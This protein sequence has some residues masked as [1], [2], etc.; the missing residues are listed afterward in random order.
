M[1]KQ[2]DV[3]LQGQGSKACPRANA[4]GIEKIHRAC[5][6][7]A[8]N[9]GARWHRLAVRRVG[10]PKHH[11]IGIQRGGVRDECPDATLDTVQMS[12]RQKQAMSLKG[13]RHFRID[14]SVRKPISIASY[15]KQRC[16]VGPESIDVTQAVTQKQDCVNTADLSV[17]CR[18]HSV[19]SSV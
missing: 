8:A 5:Q 16:S 18:L 3:L 10:V 11:D 17:D 19:V 15:R 9:N 2:N 1:R 12:M 7:L 4:T 13:K 14:R 6:R